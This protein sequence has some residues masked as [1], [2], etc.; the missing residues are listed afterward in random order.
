MR[1]LLVSS[2][3]GSVRVRSKEGWLPVH[4]AAKGGERDA[5]RYLVAQWPRSVH[6]KT[7]KGWLP[8]HLAASCRPF[9]HRELECALDVAR[10]LV[11]Q[12]PRSVWDATNEGY[13]PIHVAAGYASSFVGQSDSE[14][15]EEWRRVV[16]ETEHRLVR[17]LVRHAPTSVRIRARDGRLPVHLAIEEGLSLPTV[18]YL[19]ERWSEE[20]G[21]PESAQFTTGRGLSALHLAASREF[22]S[23]EHVEFLLRLAPQMLLEVDP[24]GRLP[25]HCAA[26]CE[27]PC[28]DVCRLLVERRPES[29]RRAASDGSL[30]L[31]A[32]ANRW[33]PSLEKIQYFVGQYAEALAVKDSDGS[34]PLHVALAQRK[35]S[36]EVAKFLVEQDPRSLRQKDGTG[37]LPLHIAAVW[38]AS[39]DVLYYLASKDPGSVYTDG[40]SRERPRGRKRRKTRAFQI[41]Q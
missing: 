10:L 29:L 2:W 30:P 37:L 3:Q 12:H 38:H 32:C 19:W 24:D 4:E 23:V 14:D 7:N 28:L 21:T 35:V 36:L 13:L 41:G 6:E 27:H 16:A 33:E 5:V 34:L 20:D 8:I 15:D 25:V 1:F 9:D 22:P 18:E 26:A 40:R 39:L 11:G 31:H 17:F